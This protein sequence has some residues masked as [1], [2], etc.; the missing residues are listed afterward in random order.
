MHSG[1]SVI[2]GGKSRVGILIVR[3]HL[4]SRNDFARKIMNPACCVCV[5]RLNLN[6][7]DALFPQDRSAVLSASFQRERA[8]LIENFTLPVCVRELMTLIH[9]TTIHT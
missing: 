1:R 4:A 6:G 9:N 2:R 5:S 8:F 3:E 7:S